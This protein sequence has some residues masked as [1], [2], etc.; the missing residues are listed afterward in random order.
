MESKGWNKRG[1]CFNDENVKAMVKFS[2]VIPAYNSAWCIRRCLDSVLNQTYKDWEVLVIDNYSE[3]GTFD[4][5]NGYKDSRIRGFQIHNNG[6]IA[7]SR[8]KGIKE[9]QGEWICFLDSDDWWTED[10]L[11]SCIPYLQ[12]N[13]LIYHD[14]SILKN[15]LIIYRKIEK[16][17]SQKENLIDEMLLR[18]NP[19]ANS[20]VVIRK[21]IIDE[22]GPLTE[23]VRFITVE[24]IDYWLRVLLITSK[25]KYIPCSLGFYWIGNNASSSIKH[26]YAERALLAKFIRYV[27]RE[28]REKAKSILSYKMARI[29]HLNGYFRKSM[30]YYINSINKCPMSRNAMKAFLLMFLCLCGIK[31]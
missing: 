13:D 17:L 22:A 4:I 28:N 18:E 12:G 27:S 21:Q 23:D 2:V 6:I 29:F 1:Y 16:V 19:I 8:N 26:A 30:R 10:K 31:R 9:A 7:A 20:S 25:V 24:D 11:E 5:I 15:N 14:L 3:D